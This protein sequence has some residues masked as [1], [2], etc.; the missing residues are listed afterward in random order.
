MEKSIFSKCEKRTKMLI[1]EQSSFE[2]CLNH[3]I[4]WHGSIMNSH[5]HITHSTGHQFWLALPVPRNDRRLHIQNLI[6]IHDFK[7]MIYIKQ[8]EQP[9]DRSVIDFDFGG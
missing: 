5:G 2:R 7:W 6:V 4:V 9:N 3:P 1:G 8:S